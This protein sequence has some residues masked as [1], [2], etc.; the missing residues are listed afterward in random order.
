MSLSE[1]KEQGYFALPLAEQHQTGYSPSTDIPATASQASQS[2][3]QVSYWDEIA[4]K[5][6]QI[7]PQDV[8][9]CRELGVPLP[10]SYYMRRIQENFRWM[11]YNGALRGA[12]CALSGVEIQTS[13]PSEYDGRI[14]SEAEYVKKVS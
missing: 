3:T 14:L 11:P 13:W 4:H 7:L 8:N 1:Q 9:F 2:T 6:F 5:P 12:K 10:S